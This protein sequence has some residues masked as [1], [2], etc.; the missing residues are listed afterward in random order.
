MDETFYGVQYQG[1]KINMAANVYRHIVGPEYAP[2]CDGAVNADMEEILESAGRRAGI[3]TDHLDMT[4]ARYDYMSRIHR[5]LE[6]L[7][8]AVTLDD[9]NPLYLHIDGARLSD[10][11]FDDIHRLMPGYISRIRAIPVAAMLVSHHDDGYVT[12]HDGYRTYAPEEWTALVD[13]MDPEIYAFAFGQPRPGE[14]VP[15]TNQDIATAY[16]EY[17]FNHDYEQ[18]EPDADDY[19]LPLMKLK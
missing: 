3:D 4:G 1:D 15:R 7:G 18:W 11:S 13:T 16:W 14:R 5:I 19:A 17:H 9:D 8:S 12:L 2:K 10:L 6:P